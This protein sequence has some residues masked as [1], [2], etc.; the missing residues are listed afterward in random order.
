M[1]A[2]EN[3]KNT[4]SKLASVYVVFLF[5]AFPLFVH[6]MYFDIMNDK[7][8]LFWVSCAVVAGASLIITLIYGLTDLTKDHGRGVKAF[9]REF[10]PANIKKHLSLPDCFFILFMVISILSTVLSEYPYE[11]FWGQYGRYQ[12]LFLWIFY[13]ALYVLISRFYRAKRWHFDLFLLVGV[14]LSLW[15]CLDYIG[16]DPLGWRAAIGDPSFRYDFSSGIGN[17]NSLTAM[18]AL[19]MSAAAVMFIDQPMADFKDKCRK[20]LYGLAL[21]ITFTAVIMSASDNGA[22]AVGALLF[23][24]PFYAWK[25][26]QG[27]LSYL[28]AAALFMLAMYGTGSITAWVH[29]ANAAAQAAGGSFFLDIMPEGK[30]GVLLMLSNKQTLLMAELF[31]ILCFIGVFMYFLDF[32]AYQKK[33]KEVL[34]G[35]H[36]EDYMAEDTGKASRIV[37]GLLGL[38]ALIGLIWLFYDANTGGHPEWYQNYSKFFIFNDRW[39]TNRGYNWKLIISYFAML[40]LF[41]KFIGAGPETYGVYTGIR[42]YYTMLEEM[43][44]TYDSPHNEVLQYLFSVGIIGTIGYYGMVISAIF[45]GIFGKSGKSSG[46]PAKAD[47]KATENKSRKAADNGNDVKS[48][49]TDPAKDKNRLRKAS[50][51]TISAACAFAVL[52]YTAASVVNISAPTVTPMM[53]LLL[54]ICVGESHKA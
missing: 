27:T 47:G 3:L 24:L 51:T 29:E 23:V 9:F 37:W 32:S 40:P 8:Y 2:Y 31:V 21:L 10:L 13:G 25:N 36:F 20:V 34:G 1:T 54:S 52:A 14:I 45:G 38:S 49:G 41:R 5:I 53:L 26:R 50:A 48:D 44:E 17:V 11:A 43:N 42:D 33:R 28:A 46:W 18:L 12:G 35:Y 4:I 15:G 6:D 19:Y 7:F 16:A 39:G 22:L 30:W